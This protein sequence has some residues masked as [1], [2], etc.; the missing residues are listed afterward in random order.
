MKA[1]QTFELIQRIPISKSPR[2]SNGF[3]YADICFSS[4]T[5]FIPKSSTSKYHQSSKNCYALEK[6]V[7]DLTADHSSNVKVLIE[8]QIKS[9]MKNELKGITKIRIPKSDRDHPYVY[10]LDGFVRLVEK[11]E[12]DVKL[13][14]KDEEAVI[15]IIRDTVD[16][17]FN[18][19]IDRGNPTFKESGYTACEIMINIK[20]QFINGTPDQDEFIKMILKIKIGTEER[21]IYEAFGKQWSL[22]M[23]S[24]MKSRFLKR[25][26]LEQCSR[27]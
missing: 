8:N 21:E 18:P 26:F 19:I 16:N 1:H 5:S 7:Q 13:V 15:D 27:S 12:I 17:Y 24:V 4:N 10:K 20:D 3:K 2:F 9:E 14:Q 6:L 25:K 23:V 22:L 11:R